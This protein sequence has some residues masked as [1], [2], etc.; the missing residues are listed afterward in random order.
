VESLLLT[1]GQH[2]IT[3]ERSARGTALDPVAHFHLSNGAIAGRL[4]FMANMSP[5][6]LQESAGMM[7]NYVYNINQIETNCMNYS[8]QGIVAHS[9]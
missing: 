9:L 7:I 8:E 2:Y 4:N 3:Q 1:L 6:G 5:K